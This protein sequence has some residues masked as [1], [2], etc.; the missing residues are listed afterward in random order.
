MTDNHFTS[1]TKCFMQRRG[2]EGRGAQVQNVQTR[3]AREY[4]RRDQ[5]VEELRCFMESLAPRTER[6]SLSLDK[7]CQQRSPQLALNAQHERVGEGRGTRGPTSHHARTHIVWVM[8]KP[9][10]FMWPQSSNYA[11]SPF[12]KRR[13]LRRT[14]R[15]KNRCKYCSSHAPRYFIIIITIINFKKCIILVLFF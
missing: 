11:W 12:N 9:I 2:G 14:A 1:Q 8:S 10:M 15:W 7:R 3:L 13:D 5:T 6:S 4:F